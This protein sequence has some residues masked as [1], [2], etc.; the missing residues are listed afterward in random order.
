MYI[1]ICMY[2]YIHMSGTSNQ[3]VAAHVSPQFPPLSGPPPASRSP[4]GPGDFFL[5]IISMTY[6]R[7]N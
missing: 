2:I 7:V 4:S 1:Y 3:L 6:P 5:G